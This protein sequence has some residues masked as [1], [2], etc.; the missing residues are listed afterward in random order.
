MRSNKLLTTI[1]ISLLAL[2][3]NGQAII[4]FGG[5]RVYDFGFVKEGDKVTHIFEFGN[6]GTDTS[7]LV[8]SKV[9]PSCGCTSPNW[10][11]QPFMS[12]ESGEID[13]TY[14]SK[15]R[16]GRFYKHITVSSNADEPELELIIKGVVVAKDKLPSDSLLN[17]IESKSP[18]LSFDRT[19]F[20]IGKIE[21]GKQSILELTVTNTGKEAVTIINSGTGCSCIRVDQDIVIEAGE[22]E[23]VKLTYTARQLESQLDKLVLVTDEIDHP[24]YEIKF[25]A[26]VLKSL[27]EKDNMMNQNNAPGG[28]G[29]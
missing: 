7:S 29:F 27:V 9:K 11:R 8:L 24:I 3:I 1:V 19:L 20:N 4:N 13:V 26:D 25:K 14:N 10:P 22:S 17:A 28:F 18:N 23:S 21:K 2:S 16:V 12:G 5:E 6:D 15:G